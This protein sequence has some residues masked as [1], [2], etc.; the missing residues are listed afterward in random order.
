MLNQQQQKKIENSEILE[1]FVAFELTCSPSFNP[2]Y[3]V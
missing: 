3:L 2:C 1:S